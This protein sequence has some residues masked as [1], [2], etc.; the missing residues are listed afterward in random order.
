[1][2]ENSTETNAPNARP[3][4]AGWCSFCRKRYD[5]VGPLVEGPDQVYICLA[6]SLRCVGIIRAECE[7]RGIPLPGENDS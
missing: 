6:C 4:G 2:A 7:R 1:M 3:S 5:V